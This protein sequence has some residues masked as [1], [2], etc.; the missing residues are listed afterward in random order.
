MPWVTFEI[1]PAR[2]ASQTASIAITDAEHAQHVIDANI[3]GVA[4]EPHFPGG[5][6]IV[7]HSALTDELSRPRTLVCPSTS[8]SATS[9]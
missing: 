3:V 8:R 1:R 5:A 9:W 2:D 6:R 4:E 7:P